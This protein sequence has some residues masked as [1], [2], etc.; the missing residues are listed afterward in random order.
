VESTRY[1]VPG[2][3]EVRPDA[4]RLPRLQAL[5]NELEKNEIPLH[6]R[7]GACKAFDDFVK[8]GE[9]KVILTDG[10]EELSKLEDTLPACAGRGVG[11]VFRNASFQIYIQRVAKSNERDEILAM[12]AGNALLSVLS[13]RPSLAITRFCLPAGCDVTVFSP[14]VELEDHGRAIMS[15]GSDPY[16][17]KAGD[18][19][20]LEP[21]DSLIVIKVVENYSLP[22]Q[23][24]FDGE[25]L[26]SLFVAT[27]L[28]SLTRPETLLDLAMALHGEGK[29]IPELTDVVESVTQHPLH[30]VRWKAVQILGR[31]NP[32]SAKSVLHRF[33]ND[34][35]PHIR[36][37]SQAALKKF[38]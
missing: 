9:H 5:L 26:R 29:G 22:Y 4:R 14:G 23:W 30:F 21:S 2:G 35:H 25:T 32:A 8:S 24:A 34:T 7:A 16:I 3:P 18:V 28:P 33:V 6:D 19:L 36:N 13:E 11:I 17:C 20:L 12:T 1:K 31:I 15:F 38:G 10:L 27:S 37:S